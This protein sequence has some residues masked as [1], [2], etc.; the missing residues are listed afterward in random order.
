MHLAQIRPCG[1]LVLEEPSPAFRMRSRRSLPERRP[2]QLAK[3]GKSRAARGAHPAAAAPF[4]AALLLPGGP[5]PVH[6]VKAVTPSVVPTARTQGRGG[7]ARETVGG[8]HADADSGGPLLDVG[9]PV[10]C[11]VLAA[12]PPAWPQQTGLSDHLKMPG[13]CAWPRRV[14]LPC[15]SS[16]WPTE[17]EDGK[18]REMTCQC[19]GLGSA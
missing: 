13:L 9:Q 4:P 2:L 6:L 18:S 12:I 7:C 16:R 5:A 3:S 14:E 19:L 15:R 10:R 1:C 17:N 8:V 11:G